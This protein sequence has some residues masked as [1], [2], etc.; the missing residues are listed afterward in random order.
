MIH[1]RTLTSL[2]LL[3][4]LRKNRSDCAADQWL[5][6]SINLESGF[7]DL[8]V[9]PN[10]Y[11]NIRVCD[12]WITQKCCHCSTAPL[13]GQTRPGHFGSLE[14]AD[15]YKSSVQK[16]QLVT[17]SRQRNNFNLEGLIQHKAA[18]D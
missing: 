12:Y 4:S 11:L 9:V 10:E 1:S 15:L 2:L 16:L 5:R 14:I 3:S 13:S 6:L 18:V 7:K 8:L 17:I